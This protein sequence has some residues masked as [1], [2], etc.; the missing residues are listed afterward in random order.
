MLKRDK[1]TTAY[2]A[3]IG[4]TTGNQPGEFS[5]ASA[6]KIKQVAGQGKDNYLFTLQ[7]HELG[8]SASEVKDRLNIFGLNEVAHEKAPKWYVQ[9]FEA[10]LNPFIG[11][12]VVLAIISLITDVIIQAA[13]DKGDTKRHVAFYTGVQE[14]PSSGEVK[15]DG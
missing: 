3:A 1:I 15:V 14:Q 9:F 5:T 7:S 10:F 8:L 11:V 6:L 2:K 4:K 13:A 12:L